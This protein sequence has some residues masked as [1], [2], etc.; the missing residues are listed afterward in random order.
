MLVNN[1]PYRVLLPAWL[2][3]SKDKLTNDEFIKLVQEYLEKYER[4]PHYQLI[5]VDKH[6]A[7]CEKLE[8]GRKET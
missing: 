2:L 1:V 4:Y 7:I 8:E 6:F 5:T 3:E